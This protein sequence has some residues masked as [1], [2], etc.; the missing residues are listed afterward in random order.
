MRRVRDGDYAR[1]HGADSVELTAAV[2]AELG[3]DDDDHRLSAASSTGT[4]RDQRGSRNDA[5]KVR[6]YEHL[7]E[8]ERRGGDIRHVGVLDDGQ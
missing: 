6:P 5:A 8:F 2:L 7:A 1:R 3:Q 4:R